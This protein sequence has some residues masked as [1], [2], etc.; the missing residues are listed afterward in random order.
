MGDS[1][2][3]MAEQGLSSQEELLSRAQ[4]ERV[5]QTAQEAPS[6]TS[7]GLRFPAQH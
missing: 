3:L 4:I 7:P 2:A 6:F 1:H 5:T